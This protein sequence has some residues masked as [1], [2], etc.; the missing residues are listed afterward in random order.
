MPILR[1]REENFSGAAQN[2]KQSNIL[3]NNSHAHESGVRCN[4]PDRAPIVGEL[5]NYKIASKELDYLSKNAQKPLTLSKDC[6]WPDLYVSAAHGSNG[7]VTCPFSAEILASMISREPLPINKNIL[8][9]IE[10]LR[11]LIRELK[12]QRH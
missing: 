7:A 2:F 1:A 6:Y 12:K 10:S 5:S 8:A 9:S 3:E 4:A 11:F